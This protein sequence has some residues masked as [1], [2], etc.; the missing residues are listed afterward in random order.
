MII[1]FVKWFVVGIVH[2]LVLGLLIWSTIAS[3]QPFH[4]HLL[5]VKSCISIEHINGQIM[6]NH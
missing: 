4:P 6:H 2:I 3:G 1:N 5:K